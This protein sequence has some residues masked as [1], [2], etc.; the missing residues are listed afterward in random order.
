VRPGSAT[1]QRE[2]VRGLLVHRLLVRGLL[3]PSLLVRR[4]PVP[5][6]LVRRRLVRRLPVPS[7]L[8]RRLPVP[9]LLVRRPPV[10]SLLVLGLLVP[11]LASTAFASTALA[12]AEPS[13]VR[14]AEVLM[15]DACVLPDE[16]T[17]T[18][19]IVASARGA[20]VRAYTSTDLET[21][22]GPHIIYR[23]P[24][25]MWGADVDIRGIWAPELHTYNGKYY[26]FLTFD[27][28]AELPEQWDGWFRWLPRVRRASQILVSDSPL[29]PF[30]PF[31]NEP[32]LPPEMMTLDGTLWVEDGTPYMVYS[33]EWVQIVDGAIAM[34]PLEADLSGTAGEST[35][36]FRASDAPWGERG[37]T[38]GSWVTDGPWLH[39]SESG[40]L[41]M[42]W[43]SFSETGYTVGLAVSESGR[44]AGPWIQQAEPIYRDDGGHPMLFRTFDGRLVMSL[45]APN[46]GPGQRI[47]FFETEDTS[48]TLRII[49]ELAPE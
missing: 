30:E 21:W 49:R 17:G 5:S 23:T 16:T 24:D 3:V 31:S 42:L 14:L 1:D 34:V 18:Y 9:S 36:L 44:L 40:R 27:S 6:L 4:L 41:F 38:Y 32:T 43:S 35:V 8:V 48:E 20:A 28:R 22:E 45:H 12:Q 13:T 15:R 37:D 39:R 46:S 7:L 47:R 33:H 29:G 19:Y 2:A 10:P 25:E 11:A 26:L